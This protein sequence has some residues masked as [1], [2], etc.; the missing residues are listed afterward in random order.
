MWLCLWFFDLNYL[1]IYLFLG[2]GDV[3]R[4]SSTNFVILGLVLCR[5][6]NATS[7]TNL[8]Q[9]GFINSAAARAKFVR[10]YDA[11]I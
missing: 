9:L 5:F 11:T 7:W 4:Y 2:G 8:D 10:I 3:N 6:T 1:L